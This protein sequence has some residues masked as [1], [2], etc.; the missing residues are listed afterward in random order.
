MSTKN[1]YSDE[2]KKK[3]KDIVEDIS[4]TMMVTDLGSVPLS[5][6]PMDTKKVDENGDI[7]F[8]SGA[9]SDHNSDILKNGA[10]QLLYS[11]PGDKKFLSV[12]G[13]ATIVADDEII[14]DI[15]EKTD[16]AYLNGPD[17]PNTTAIR[18]TPKEA[19]YWD[20]DENTLKVLFKLAKASVT[21]ENQDIGTMGSLKM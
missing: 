13:N 1:L 19:V 12:Y 2:A 15:Y 14:A 11:G 4:Y 10:T 18:F 3:L 20:S 6:I 7:W 21:G 17:D 5:A 16:N 8:L 9:D